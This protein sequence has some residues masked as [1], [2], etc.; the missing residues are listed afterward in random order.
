MFSIADIEKISKIC[1]KEHDLECEPD[2]I[3]KKRKH[4]IK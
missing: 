4:K 1:D 3:E 2:Y